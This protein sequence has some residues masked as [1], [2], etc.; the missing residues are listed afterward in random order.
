MQCLHEG[1]TCLSNDLRFGLKHA[2]MQSDKEVFKGETIPSGYASWVGT[3]TDR[4]SYPKQPNIRM[5]MYSFTQWHP[6][7]QCT[8]FCTCTCKNAVA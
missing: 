6:S 5:Y 1:K 4:V 3:H 2:L 7:A 8:F